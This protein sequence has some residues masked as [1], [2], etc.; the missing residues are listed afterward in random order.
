MAIITYKQALNQALKEEMKRDKNVFVI[1]EDVAK[2]Q[3]AYRV[4]EGLLYEFGADRVK[5]TPISEEVVVGVG[6]GSAMLGLRPVVE[7]MTVNFSLLAIDQIVNHA[8]KLRY[9]SNGQITV[10][11]VIRMPEGAGMQLGAQHSQSFESWFGYIPGLK[12]VSVSNP[13]DAK[14]LLKSAIRDDNPVIFLEHELLYSTKGEVPENDYTIPIGKADIKR[15]GKDITL[16]SYSKMVSDCLGAASQLEKDGINSEVI[17]LRSLRPLD[18]DMIIES[19][20]KTHHAVVVEEDWP[21]Y[22]IGAQIAATIQEHAFDHLDA[23]VTRVTQADV[24]MPYSAELELSAL[25]NKAQIIERVKAVM[26]R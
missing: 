2:Y 4:T 24:P 1:G 12:V 10:P 19:V 5:D 18:V 17:D 16:I 11:M 9:M 26:N 8:T 22:G 14:G 13:Y 15:Q 7:I 23:P 25:P 21:L 20:K 6:V 3:G